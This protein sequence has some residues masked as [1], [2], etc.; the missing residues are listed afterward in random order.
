MILEPI[1]EFFHSVYYGSVLLVNPLTFHFFKSGNKIMIKKYIVIGKTIN[2]RVVS[3]VY[4]RYVSDQSNMVK[5][6]VFNEPVISNDS[7]VF[8]IGSYLTKMK[9]NEQKLTRTFEGYNGDMS[10]FK[11]SVGKFYPACSHVPDMFECF[12]NLSEVSIMNSNVLDVEML[13]ELLKGLFYLFYSRWYFSD[14]YT[15]NNKISL[16]HLLR[17]LIA[18]LKKKEFDL[19]ECRERSFL[20][21]IVNETR[22]KQE[23]V[24]SPITIGII[25]KEGILSSS[26][27]FQIYDEYNDGVSEIRKLRE[28]NNEISKGKFDLRNILLKIK[29]INDAPMLDDN[30]DNL[31][32]DLKTVVSYSDFCKSIYLYIAILNQYESARIIALE[33]YVKDADDQR[34]KVSFLRICTCALSRCCSK[35]YDCD[36]CNSI[37]KVLTWFCEKV[38]KSEKNK[39][40]AEGFFAKIA[41]GNYDSKVF[42][43]LLNHISQTE[44][45]HYIWTYQ[46]WKFG[47]ALDYPIKFNVNLPD[48]I[49][50]GNFVCSVGLF[51]ENGI[52]VK[53][54]CMAFD[55][56]FRSFKI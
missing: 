1:V 15:V 8:T 21:K 23:Q 37:K 3:A 50:I 33:E 29:E 13:G 25:T 14:D 4:S 9:I 56:T 36:D 35:Q 45:E 31:A 47:N 16:D 48:Q 42:S 7:I 19:N 40:K 43:G 2:P 55:P 41:N 38:N 18:K 32:D 5:H 10:I 20:L 22:K 12:G 26:E 51:E 17:E 28:I 34:P 49:L 39:S 44:V 6:L 24:R 54:K 27:N 30:Y 52:V 11:D 46:K 53:K